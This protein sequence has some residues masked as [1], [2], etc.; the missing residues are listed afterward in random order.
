MAYEPPVNSALERMLRDLAEGDRG[1]RLKAIK[2]LRARGGREPQVLQALR[3]A[4][5]SDDPAVQAQARDTLRAL[6]LDTALAARQPAS[7]RAQVIEFLIGF[8]GWWLVNGLVWWMTDT[9]SG[10]YALW[11]MCVLPINL[12]LLLVFLRARRYVGWGILATY[13]VNF[14]LALF[15]NMLLNGACW[16]PFFTGRSP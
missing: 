7:R 2:A 10:D 4:E 13:A 11:N 16:I 1:A 12:V 3:Q 15:T 5:A 14:A 9:T 6:T 8:V